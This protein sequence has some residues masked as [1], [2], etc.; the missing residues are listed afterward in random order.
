MNKEEEKKL[1][2]IFI[3]ESDKYKSRPMYEAIVYAAKRAGIAG[4]TVTRGLMSFGANSRIHSIKIFSLSTDLPI[5][6][7][8][9]D[10]MA[11]IKPFIEIVD[12]M[13]TK[14]NIGGMITMEKIEVIRYS[15]KAK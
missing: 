10:D 13:F 11:K 6:I 4:A 5:I 14:A 1:L 3:G 9:V 15:G 8:I 7:E 12:K 2:R